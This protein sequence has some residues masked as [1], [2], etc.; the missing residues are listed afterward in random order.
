[1]SEQDEAFCAHTQRLVT[2]PTSQTI[3]G[4]QLNEKSL[5]LTFG[6][7]SQLTV[8]DDGQQCCEYRYLHT[9]D[10]LAYFIGSTYLG[11]EYRD[12]EIAG[13]YDIGFLLISTSLG[14]FTIEAHNEHNGHY[15]GF[16]ISAEYLYLEG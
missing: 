7:N 15:V 8:W 14:A 1:M 10:D 5:V 4:A 3:V 12:V 13:D 2:K 6:N 9:D 11:M 16:D